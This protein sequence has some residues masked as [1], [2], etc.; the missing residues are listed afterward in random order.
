M[1]WVYSRSSLAAPIAPVAPRSLLELTG[2]RVVFIPQR[3]RSTRKSCMRAK[4]E[5]SFCLTR[6]LCVDLRRRRCRTG[7]RA[8]PAS[9]SNFRQDGVGS[10]RSLQALRQIRPFHHRCRWTGSTFPF[11][12]LRRLPT[13]SWRKL[14]LEAW[15]ALLSVRHLLLRRT[16][17]RQQR[18]QKDLSFLALI[19]DFLVL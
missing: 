2:L 11:S 3:C 12:R 8:T 7:R 5:I 6:C 10:R 16:E 9:N 15:V 19:D 13:S 4:N 14:G 1:A 18:R 17:Q